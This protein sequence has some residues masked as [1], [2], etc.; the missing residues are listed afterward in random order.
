MI[1]GDRETKRKKVKEKLF[2]REK[3]RLSSMSIC[4]FFCIFL[5]RKI[6]VPD[7]RGNP[8]ER[9]PVLPGSRNPDDR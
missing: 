8:K 4:S 7:R 2:C 9:V 6:C 1:D 3:S 5:L